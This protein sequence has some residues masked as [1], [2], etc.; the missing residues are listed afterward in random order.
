MGIISEKDFINI[1]NNLSD[2]SYKPGERKFPEVL[3]SHDF[4]YL[5]SGDFKANLHVHSMYS[6]GTMTVEEIFQ[7]AREISNKDFLIALTDHDTVEGC[8]KALELNSDGIN[9]CLGLEISTIAINF[10]SQPKPLPVHLLVYGI[11]PFDEKL[12]CYLNRKR[13]LKLQLAKKTIEKLNKEIKGYDFSLEEAAR[14]HSMIAK[15][16]DEIAHPLKKYTA[17]KILLDYYFPNANFSYERPLFKYKYLFNPREPYYITYKKALEMFTGCRL[18]IIPEEIIQKIQLA[19]DIYSEAHPSIGKMLDAFSS[20]EEAVRF[21]STLDSGVMSIAH[22]ARTTAYTGEFYT[23]LFKYFKDYGK[24]K[25]LFYEGC[26]QSYEGKYF[27]QWQSIIDDAA[28][29][30]GLRKTGGLDSHGKDIVSRCP[31][32]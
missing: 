1:V 4:R 19:K 28:S 10:P 6:D 21:V 2:I 29:R 11:N 9:I 8:K 27:L 24:E 12:N 13:D 32:Y 3:D 7:K 26:Y 25:A 20:F 18:D 17:A 16:Q 23:Y 5:E 14:C 15:G 22:P 31:H 30:F